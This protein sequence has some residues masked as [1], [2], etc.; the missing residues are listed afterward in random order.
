MNKSDWFLVMEV[1]KVSI[2]LLYF[3]VLL[4]VK[5]KNEKG[6]KNKDIEVE[7]GINR[8]SGLFWS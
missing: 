5:R 7:F 1:R 8:G 6:Q 2:K 3:V 4:Y